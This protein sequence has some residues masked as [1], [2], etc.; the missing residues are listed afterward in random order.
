MPPS[1]ETS[2]HSGGA[3]P[4]APTSAAAL[5]LDMAAS[6]FRMADAG[7][8]ATARPPE[9]VAPAAKPGPEAK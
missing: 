2:R 6:P 8:A 3:P 9:A 7:L 1:D 5:P 4:A